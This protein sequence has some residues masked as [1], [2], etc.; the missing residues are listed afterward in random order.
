MSK[1]S[2]DRGRNSPTAAHQ[3]NL[4]L[5]HG[6]DYQPIAG[7]RQ[8]FWV[9]GRDRRLRDHNLR[10]C[11]VIQP[12]AALHRAILICSYLY[13]NFPVKWLFGLLH[14]LFGAERPFLVG[15]IAAALI[16]LGS[17]PARPVIVDRTFRPTGDPR[18]ARSITQRLA[19]ISKPA[20]SLDALLAK[21]CASAWSLILRSDRGSQVRN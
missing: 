19:S 6:N 12:D 2:A 4:K 18:Q 13:G 7:D 1:C 21:R 10:P 15:T 14:S 3:I 5:A 8:L 9:S 16:L 11:R 20:A 17:S